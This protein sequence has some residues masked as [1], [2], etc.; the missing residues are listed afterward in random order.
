MVFRTMTESGIVPDPVSYTSL[1]DTCERGQVLSKVQELFREMETS[2][3]PPDVVGYNILIDAFGRRG[4]CEEAESVIF[5]FILVPPVFLLDF[6]L[7]SICDPPS[8]SEANGSF[9]S[10]SQCGVV[11]TST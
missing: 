3:S 8:G 6:S 5:C 2:G 11:L 9:K 4:F 7:I 10:C 1:V